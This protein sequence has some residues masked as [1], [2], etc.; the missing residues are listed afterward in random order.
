MES[1][2]R[3]ESHSVPTFFR[4][5]LCCCWENSLSLGDRSQLLHWGT[6]TLALDRRAGSTLWELSSGLIAQAWQH[7]DGHGGLRGWAGEVFLNPLV[8]RWVVN[9]I[10]S[11]A[12][13]GSEASPS[14]LWWMEVLWKKGQDGDP[15]LCGQLQEGGI[16]HVG[17]GLQLI[18]LTMSSLLGDRSSPESRRPF[19]SLWV[20]DLA[21]L[22]VSFPRWL[23]RPQW[24]NVSTVRGSLCGSPTSW[25]GKSL[26]SQIRNYLKCHL[27]SALCQAMC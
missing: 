3:P 10:S 20:R 8:P 1:F 19:W 11:Q 6:M 15:Q 21:S 12:L 4:G 18:V 25:A 22:P 7:G 5:W 17:K 2:R 9:K 24:M 13:G 26:P 16:G 23:E 14:R 27:L